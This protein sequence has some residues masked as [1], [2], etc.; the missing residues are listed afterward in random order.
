M[1]YARHP[2]VSLRNTAQRSD[3]LRGSHLI[4]ETTLRC[5][6]TANKG[7]KQLTHLKDSFVYPYPSIA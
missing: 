3:R 1:L 6:K 2:S 4:P 7:Q 5:L